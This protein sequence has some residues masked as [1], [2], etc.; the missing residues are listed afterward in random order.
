MKNIDVLY[1]D[2]HCLV[3]NKPAG[4]AVQGGAGVGVNLDAL[5]SAAYS[6]RPLLVHRLDK[7]TSGIIIT[8]KNPEAAA[9]FS[10]IIAGRGAL[11]QYTALSANETGGDPAALRGSGVI[12]TELLIK[13]EK[14]YAE[15][16]YSILDELTFELGTG[17]LTLTVFAL[18]PGTGRMHQIRRSL[19]LKK[20]PVLGDDKYGDFK[21]NK[22]LKK[23]RGLKNLLLHA[24]RL[25]LALPGGNALDVSAPL[26]LYFEKIY[27][28]AKISR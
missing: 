18:E 28:C 4:L 3:L 13:G 8:A 9:W 2:D 21:L 11:K 16:A 7:E 27:P 26:P 15:T 17:P 23:E 10:K 12:K 20:Y 1:E 19:A 25:K 6:P 22:Q 14:K 5:L 24:S